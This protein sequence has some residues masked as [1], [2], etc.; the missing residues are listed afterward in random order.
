[1]YVPEADRRHDMTLYRQNGLDEQL[2]E[3]LYINNKQYCLYGY[4]AYVLRAWL[5]IAFDRNKATADE[6]QHNKGIRSV[7]EAV[8][9]TYKDLR[10]IWTSQNFRKILRVRKS[11]IEMLYNAAAYCGTFASAY[12]VCMQMRM[13]HSRVVGRWAS[14]F[15]ADQ[16]PLVST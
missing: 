13:F 8:E 7:R 11:P 1:M 15:I 10:Q 5:Q 12:T 9:W 3:H 14:T 4:P 16:Q 2:E 6:L